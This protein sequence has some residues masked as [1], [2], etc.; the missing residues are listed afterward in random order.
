MVLGKAEIASVEGGEE[1]SREDTERGELGLD[2]EG[3][4]GRLCGEYVIC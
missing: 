3:V 4:L 2:E 1:S